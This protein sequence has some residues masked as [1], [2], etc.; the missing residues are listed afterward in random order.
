MIKE[1]FK[2]TTFDQIVEGLTKPAKKSTSMQEKGFEGT[3]EEIEG[4]FDEINEM[5]YKRNLTDGELP[6]VPP[7]IEKVEEFLKYTERSP[8]ET[9][10]ELLPA[11]LLATPSIIAAN[12]VMAGCQSG[13]HADIDSGGRGNS[14]SRLGPGAHR[15]DRRSYSV[16]SY[17]WADH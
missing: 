4:T 3:A 12:G 6:I 13:A 5:F 2:K 16:P 8:H 14:R 9:I 10:A 17:K 15:H 1:N 7:T 11:S